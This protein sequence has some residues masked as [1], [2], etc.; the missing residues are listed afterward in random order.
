M[1]PVW[2]EEKCGVIHSRIYISNSEWHEINPGEY[3]IYLEIETRKDVD[4][5]SFGVVE[6]GSQKL[7]EEEDMAI[8]RMPE[9]VA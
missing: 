3:D 4:Q 5:K 2:A 6:P 1:R 8:H 7:S 9:I